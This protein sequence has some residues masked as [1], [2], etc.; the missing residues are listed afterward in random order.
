[1]NEGW[2]AWTRCPPPQVHHVSDWLCMDPSLPAG[3]NFSCSA[4]S[5]CSLS[6]VQRTGLGVPN[7]AAGHRSS[8]GQKSDSAGPGRR[9]GRWYGRVILMTY[10]LARAAKS[11]FYDSTHFS[12]ACFV[13]QKAVGCPPTAGNARR[14]L[15][16]SVL[17]RRGAAGHSAQ[18]CTAEKEGG[19]CSS[20]VYGVQRALVPAASLGS[21]LL[22]TVQPWSMAGPTTQPN[23][24]PRQHNRGCSKQT[25]F[26]MSVST[27][28]S[29]Y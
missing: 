18:G 9:R 13:R 10:Y 15:P 24:Q 27:R 25:G 3:P 19:T 11:F 17:G 5:V 6:V 8:L 1:M 7:G 23:K 12:A 4:K 22:R 14:N 28:P 20:T 26:L 21:T 29:Y 2:S 16:V